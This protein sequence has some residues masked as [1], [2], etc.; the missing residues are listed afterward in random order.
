MNVGLQTVPG[1]RRQGGTKEEADCSRLVGLVGGRFHKQRT[2]RA[3]LGQLQ[4]ESIFIPACQ[5]PKVHVEALTGI[6]H[7]FSPDGL[8]NKLLSRGS[9]LGTTFTVGMVGRA[10]IQGQGREV[11]VSSCLGPAWGSTGS[12]DVLL[13]YST[14]CW[15]APTILHT[16]LFQVCPEWCARGFTSM[17][18]ACWVAIWLYW[19]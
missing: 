16:H 17:E 13:Q 8:N 7:V 15:L 4:D 3:C 2:H 14:P 1:H 18:V 19:Q 11:V 9:A 10:Y 6:N 12:L 5:I